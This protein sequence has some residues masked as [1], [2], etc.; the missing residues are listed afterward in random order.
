MSAHT[1][2]KTESDYKYVNRTGDTLTGDLTLQN[3]IANGII[4][5][6]GSG[7]TNLNLISYQN[8]LNGQIQSLIND[9]TNNKKN[10][11]ATANMY[12]RPF[13]YVYMDDFRAGRKC[14]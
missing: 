8:T 3:L 2:T 7:I 12:I 1:Y 14:F 4:S 6:D 5:G 13:A 11:Y 10:S 9:G